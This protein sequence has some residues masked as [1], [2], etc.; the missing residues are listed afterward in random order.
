MAQI[1]KQNKNGQQIT[2]NLEN[3]VQMNTCGIH[4]FRW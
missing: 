2:G 1:N 4:C 3:K